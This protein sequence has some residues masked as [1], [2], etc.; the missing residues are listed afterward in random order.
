MRIAFF[1]NLPAGGGKRSAHEWIKRMT[2]HHDVDLFLYNSAAED[3]LDL[4]PYVK[5]TIL[6][7]GG[8]IRKGTRTEKL[9]AYFRIVNASKEIA[10]RMNSGNYDLAFIMQCQRYN[11]P[12]VLRYLHIPSLY[13]CH[14][15]TAKIL[16][17]HYNVKMNGLRRLY[18][19]WLCRIDRTN[20]R[21]ATLI[22]ANSLYSRENIYRNFGIFPRLNYLGIDPDH[23]RPLS[24]KRENIV[25]SVGSLVP[26]KAPDFLI[27]SIGTLRIK[28]AIRFIYHVSDPSYKAQL[29]LLAERLG[30]S[31]YFDYLPS[32]DEIMLAYNQAAVT[33]FPS[34]LEPMGLVPLESLACGTPVVGVAE[35]GIRETVCHGETGILTE[36]DP[37]E[38]GKAIETLCTNESLRTRMGVRGIEQVH[39]SWLWEHSYIILEK[40]MHLAIMRRSAS[41]ISK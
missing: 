1:H 5:E 16:E 13:F 33:A 2:K 23:F 17:P 10:R 9:R 18:I 22:C 30:V 21:H 29:T 12:F 39:K 8:E 15:P 35:A 38:F 36:R 26:S 19:E 31:V 41:L 28:P 34:I 11:S 40:H 27:E 7:P 24:L 4:R 20:A 25:L 32:Q 3:F 6:I 14:E 37:V